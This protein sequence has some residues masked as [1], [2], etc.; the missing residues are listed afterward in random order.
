MKTFKQ[1]IMENGSIN[2]SMPELD[3]EEK[4]SPK[5]LSVEPYSTAENYPVTKTTEK[6]RKKIKKKS[7]L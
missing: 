2:Q 1:W 5:E 4:P 7:S 6:L 3:K